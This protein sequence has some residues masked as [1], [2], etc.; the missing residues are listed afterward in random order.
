[1]TKIALVTGGGS[2]IGRTAA[3]ALASIGFTVVIAGR[4]PA[5]LDKVAGTDERKADAYPRGNET[6]LHIAAVP[7]ANFVVEYLAGKG[8]PLDARND[9]GQT[10]LEL[11]EEQ[12][13]FRYKHDKEGPHGFGLEGENAGKVIVRE[14]QTTDAF[15]RAMGIKARIASN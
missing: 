7:G 14:T 13:V 1:M 10:A 11:A 12:E 9:H 15:K 2:G 6:I 8:V 4:R 3:L 5:P